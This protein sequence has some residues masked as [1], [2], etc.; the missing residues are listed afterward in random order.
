MKILKLALLA[1]IATTAAG[2]A[3]AAP[4]YKFTVETGDTDGAGFNALSSL[5]AGT[6]VGPVATASF[7]YT[8]ALNFDNPAAQNTTTGGDL[9]STFGFSTSNI[10]GYSGSGTV[11]YDGSTAA[12]FATLTSFLNSSGSIADYGYASYYTI[13]LGTLVAGSVVS[14]THDD[15]ASLYLAGTEINPTT[16]GPTTVTTDT[17]VAPTTGD[18]TLYYGRQNG[19]PSI[20]EVSVAVPEPMSLALLGSSLVALG[21]IR[22]RR[23]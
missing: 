19:S 22:R 13:D 5:P 8:G 16:S 21:V 2:V 6:F 12:N 7:T 4:T 3:N 11:H 14:I 10:S 20:L 17:V 9:N 23:T 1:A 18:Y 15:G